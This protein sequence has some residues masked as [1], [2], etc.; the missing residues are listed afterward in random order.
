MRADLFRF[1]VTSHVPANS[2]T[3]TAGFLSP[4]ASLIAGPWAATEFYVNAGRGFHSNDAR[5]TTIRIDPVSR[6]PTDRVTPLVAATGAEIGIR[7]VAVR[8]TQLTAALWTLALGS[9]LLF[10]GDAGTT[11]AGRSS[12]RSGLELSA[13]TALTPKFHV[14]GDLSLSSARFTANELTG[15]HVSGAAGIVGSAALSLEDWRRVSA[16][17]RWRYL[18][19]LALTEDGSVRSEPTSTVNAQVSYAITPRMRL[20]LDVFNA[21]D[22]RA[23][24]VDYF[25]VSRLQGEPADGIADIHTHPMPPRTLRLALTVGF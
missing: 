2:G 25:Y 4:K 8:R 5:G 10:V 11:D 3:E 17:I 18:G 14:D 23:S 15:I 24:D 13:Y 9:E 22:S 7:T 21:L 16:G 6:Q 19:E 12:R 1:D 20:R